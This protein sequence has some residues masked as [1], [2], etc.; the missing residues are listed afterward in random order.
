[1]KNIPR[2]YFLYLM[3]ADVKKIAIVIY[4]IDLSI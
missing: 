4:Y 2:I 3:N 1:M